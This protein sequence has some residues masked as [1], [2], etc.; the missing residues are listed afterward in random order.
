MI[1]QAFQPLAFLGEARGN[2]L[3]AHFGAGAGFIQRRDLIFQRS[4]QRAQ[5]REGAVQPG[6][7]GIEFAAHGA[8]QLGGAAR[9]AF[10]GGEKMFGG[11]SASASAVRPIWLARPKAVAMAMNRTGGS[12]MAALNSAHLLQIRAR[13][14]PAARDS[15]TDRRPTPRPRKRDKHGGESQGRGGKRDAGRERGRLDAGGSAA[16]SADWP[17]AA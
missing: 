8:A 7:Q 13:Q 2:R 10:I 5:P 12:T 16:S 6:I 3:A 9:G 11:G 1:A 15:P 17:A 4:F 14:S